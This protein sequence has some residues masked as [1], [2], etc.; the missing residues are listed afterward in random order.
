MWNNAGTKIATLHGDR[1][2][3][4][5]SPD[6][7]SAAAVLTNAHERAVADVSWNPRNA[8]ELVTCSFDGTLK[9][10][11][12][13]T[14]K[15]VQTHDTG[16]H[17]L[18]LRYSPCGQYIAVCTKENRVFIVDGAD[19][20]R[21]VTEEAFE[22]PYDV[23]DMAWSTTSAYLALGLQTGTVRVLRF[24]ARRS[25]PA[26]VYSQALRGHCTTVVSLQFDPTGR[27]LALGSNDGIVSL[28]DIREWTCIKTFSRTDQPVSSVAFSHDGLLLAIGSDNEQP[29]EIVAVEADTESDP[30]LF[31]VR[32]GKHAE[33]PTVD[34][35]PL[36]HSLAIS[37]EAGGFSVFTR[38]RH[39]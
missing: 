19:V 38:S 29:I 1:N 4:V 20:S 31:T 5:W 10:W 26:L 21:T 25:P 13:R 32:S 39:D 16:A 3:Q 7:K 18:S 35:H 24:D 23:Y 28:W 2:I 11:D 36:R 15:L 12:T 17:L 27:L 22:E 30:Y 6:S 37:G 33:R 8:D 34:W 9:R 14:R